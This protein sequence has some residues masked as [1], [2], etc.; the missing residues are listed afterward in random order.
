MSADV[1]PDV[2]LTGRFARHP[3]LNRLPR[4]FLIGGVLPRQPKEIRR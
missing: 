2:C 4:D 1:Q 3:A